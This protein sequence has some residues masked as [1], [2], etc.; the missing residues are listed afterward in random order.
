MKESHTEKERQNRDTEMMVSVVVTSLFQL[1][2]V[3]PNDM[4]NITHTRS[5]TSSGGRVL[6]LLCNREYIAKGYRL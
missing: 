6:L 4:C 1:R 2:S 3:R 5:I